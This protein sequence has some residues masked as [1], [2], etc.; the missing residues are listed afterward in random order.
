MMP[1]RRSRRRIDEMSSSAPRKVVFAC[2]SGPIRDQLW[3]TAARRMAREL[4]FDVTLYPETGNANPHDWPRQLEQADAMI[5]TWGAPRLT[6]AVLGQSRLRI[7]GHAAGSVA[8][9]VSSELYDRGIRVV[10]AN[11]VMAQ[12]VAEYSLMMTLIARTRLND[13]AQ[14]AGRPLSWP[15]KLSADRVGGATIGI[16]GYGE[17]GRRLIQMLRPLAPG[18]ILIHS[19][20]LTDAQAAELDVEKVDFDSLFSRS[21]VIHLLAGLTPANRHRVGAR[22]LATIRE[23]AAL[24]NAGRADLVEPGALLEALKS[25]RFTAILD[26]H[27]EEPLP[28]TSPF[29]ALPNVILTPHSAGF[30]GREQYVPFILQEFER[31]FSGQ[32]LEAEIT[33]ERAAMMTDESIMTKTG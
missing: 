32:P 10:T 14:M 21:D 12:V 9:I 23:G 11:P 3:T 13:Y 26:V 6:G 24:V 29:R 8:G 17:I 28:E 15:E 7:I 2:A 16:W 18:Q 30:P 27:Y 25:N 1:R 5:T 20:S 4:G 19:A 22:Q 33:R 31:F